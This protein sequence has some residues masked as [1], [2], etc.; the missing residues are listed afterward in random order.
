MKSGSVI[1]IAFWR[2]E[3]SEKVWYQWCLEAPIKGTIHNPNG[4]SYFI[5]KH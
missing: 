5:K 1:E 3:N 2:S 4:R